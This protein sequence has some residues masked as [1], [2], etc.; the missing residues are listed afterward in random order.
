MLLDLR[1]RY[2][3]DT[4]RSSSPTSSYEN[5]IADQEAFGSGLEDKG[6]HVFMERPFCTYRGH[7][8]DLL[9]ISWSRNYFILTSSMDKTVRLWHISR[10]E[11]LCVFQHI[12]FVTA[13][14]FH[15]R[16]DQF[17]I[18]ASLDGKIRLWNIPD[19]KVTL[20]NEVEGPSTLITAANFIQV[21]A[22]VTLLVRSCLLHLFPTRRTVN[23]LWSALTT[24]AASST[25][26][27]SSSTTQ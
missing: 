26:P 14:A 9:D 1:A 27:T 2:N 25:A 3:A 20:W 24:A 4:Q 21:A 23:L 19:K 17:F 12:D 13:I 7:T 16:N 18:S 10:R 22:Q 5:V 6:R 8:S 11:C 15:P